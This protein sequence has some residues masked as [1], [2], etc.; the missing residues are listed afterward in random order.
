MPNVFWVIE[1]V[2]PEKS[3][4]RWHILQLIILHDFEAPAADNWNS[5]IY[6]RCFISHPEQDYH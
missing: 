2:I 6:R 4:I 3:F 1:P 5:S